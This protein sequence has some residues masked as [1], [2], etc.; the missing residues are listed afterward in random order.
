MY[1]E[2]LLIFKQL[3][4]FNHKIL[5]DKLYHYRVRG[6]AHLWFK[7]YLT[8]KKEMVQINSIDSNLNTILCGVP[9][10]SILGPLL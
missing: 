8:D 4:T 10:G 5:L 2:Y 1:V 9:Q 6:P 7:S 3:L